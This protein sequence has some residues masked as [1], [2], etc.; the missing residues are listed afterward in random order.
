MQ[1]LRSTATGRRWTDPVVGQKINKPTNNEPTNTK[2][3]KNG[4]IE[5]EGKRLK[6]NPP[7]LW[8]NHA[9]SVELNCG[10]RGCAK[11]Y[12][13]GTVYA[14]DNFGEREPKTKRDT[15]TAGLEFE[16]AESLYDEI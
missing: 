7:M 1:G 6:M 12:G 10:R 15:R 2:Q 16:V 13:C 9:L 5:R 3:D 11:C 8:R 14:T 4:N